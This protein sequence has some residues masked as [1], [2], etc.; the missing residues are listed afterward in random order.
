M[1]VDYSK[2][3]RDE[4]LYGEVTVKDFDGSEITIKAEL[5]E[6]EDE[7]IPEAEKE[8]LEFFV[9]NYLKYKQFL[10]KPIFEYYQK[11]RKAWGA[12][13]AD[14]RRFPEISDMNKM[15]EMVSLYA[16]AV[17]D[18]NNYG[19]RSISLYYNCTWDK[20]E[21]MGIMVSEFNVVKIGNSGDVY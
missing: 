5:V 21:G 12:I 20:E 13:A 10:L 18:E 4:S 16:I 17:L 3:E 1:K 7:E 19:K 14:D 8:T 9:D 15:Y 6:N 2:F 11:C